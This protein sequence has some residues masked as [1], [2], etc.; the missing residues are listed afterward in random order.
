[1]R[2][3]ERPIATGTLIT[4]ALLIWVA[5]LVNK[6]R[7]EP[8]PEP[9]PVL[10]EVAT[11]RFVILSEFTMF[12]GNHARGR[13]LFDTWHQGEDEPCV[14]VF[15]PYAFRAACSPPVD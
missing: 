12:E 14:V 1:M 6:P 2:P 11:A 7:G 13:V 9:E 8:A 10:E 3:G 5:A 4:V 15:R